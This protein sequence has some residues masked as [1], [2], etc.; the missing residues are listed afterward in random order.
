MSNKYE[1]LE[2]LEELRRAGTI[3]EEEYQNE[4]ARI[5][6]SDIN[7]SNKSSSLGVEENT[8]LMLM[9]LSQF[10]GI[11]TM[12]AGLVIPLVLW[13]VE[14]DK[15]EKVDMHGKNI[16]NFVISWILYYIVA[17]ILTI[18]V[19]LAVIGIPA[20]IVLGILN[21]IFIILAAVNASKGIY[22]KYPL[23]IPFF[24]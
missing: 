10:A 2:K 24:K 16:L 8:Y 20:L 17:F 22:W 23:T 14:K 6:N 1:L 15:S 21:I 12:G 19:I 4:R 5:M 18:T 11:L 9:H 7:Q 13:L 3:T